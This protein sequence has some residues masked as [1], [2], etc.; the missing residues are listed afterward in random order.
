MNG[1]SEKFDAE[2]YCLR[3]IKQRFLKQ[4]DLSLKIHKMAGKQI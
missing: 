3:G 1:F 4:R 2:L